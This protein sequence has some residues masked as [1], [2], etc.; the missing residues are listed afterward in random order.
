M[1]VRAI[2]AVAMAGCASLATGLPPAAQAA[3]LARVAP[4]VRSVA[5]LT[6]HGVRTGPGDGRPVGVVAPRRPITAAR[7]VLPIL[8]S[9]VQADGRS[10]LRVRLPG[11]ILDGPSPPRTG[12]ISAAGTRRSAT[13]WH[14]VV[15]L[16]ATTVDVYRS[17]RRVR[18]FRAIVGTPSTPTPRGR[19]F[20]E[21]NVRM[22][23]DAAGAPF[24][25]ATSARSSVLQ[26]FAGGPGQIALH[27][28]DN[29][30]G[31]LGTAASH[32]CVRLS[33]AA[34]T[35]LAERIAPGTPVTI[36]G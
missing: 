11:R 32:G 29:V 21:E 22:A 19:Y 30:G 34:I 10:W 35:W 15:R 20:V 25:L 2:G 3:P 28:L 26:E 24:A 14:I 33:G 27:G 5:L 8:G 1:L 36:T 23:G 4:Q 12:W 9:A 13:P 18:A 6:A 31:Q 16:R 17:S 7:T